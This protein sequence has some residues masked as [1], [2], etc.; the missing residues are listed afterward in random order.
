[1]GELIYSMMT[2][3]DGFVAGPDNDLSWALIDE[4]IHRFINDRER[5]VP[6]TLYGRRMYEMMRY[7]QTADTLTDRPQY[8]HEFA[9]IWQAKR[10]I[11]PLRAWC[12]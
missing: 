8:E 1:M 3:L 9:R 11:V 6:V 10:K 7:W 4:E 5:S 2:T 12:S